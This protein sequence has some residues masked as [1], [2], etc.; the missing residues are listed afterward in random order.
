MW[1]HTLPWVMWKV[2]TCVEG[3]PDSGYYD[4]QWL[5]GLWSTQA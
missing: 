2:V 4:T 5:T 3:Y 1:L